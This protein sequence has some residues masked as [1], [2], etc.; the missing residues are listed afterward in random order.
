MSKPMMLQDT[1]DQLI[2][3]LQKRVKA[4]TKIEVVRKALKLLEEKADRE[5]KIKQWHRAARLAAPSS[6]ETLKAFQP[7]SR[8]KKS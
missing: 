4:K 2:S 8:L 5:I 1:D 7:Y 6:Y 3:E